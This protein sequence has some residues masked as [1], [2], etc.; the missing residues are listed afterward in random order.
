MSDK[1]YRIVNLHVLYGKDRVFEGMDLETAEKKLLELI[2]RTPES[3]EM[4]C[5]FHA[6]DILKD[7]RAAIVVSSKFAV[8]AE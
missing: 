4:N 6:A 5:I 2:Q 3:N 7:C 1:K 8:Y